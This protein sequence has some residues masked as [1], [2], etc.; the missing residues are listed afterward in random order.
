M[1][2]QLQTIQHHIKSI[3]FICSGT[4]RSEYRQCG[5]PKCSCMKSEKDRH[6]PYYIWTRKADGK[7][8][9]KTLTMKQAELCKKYIG[10]MRKL[11]E[12]VK[13]WKA[14]SVKEVLKV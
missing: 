13:Q 3:D 12:V 1:N 6:G 10:N 14:V 8:I 4:I 2:Q 11:V 5:K 7:T 9:T